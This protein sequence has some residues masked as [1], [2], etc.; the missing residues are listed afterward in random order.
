LEAAGMQAGRRLT[1][2]ELA[3]ELRQGSWLRAVLAG[4]ASADY[5]EAAAGAVA[6]APARV[7][8]LLGH[9]RRT[10]RRRAAEAAAAAL[11]GCGDGTRAA[12]GLAQAVLAS[13]TAAGGEVLREEQAE[14]LGGLVATARRAASPCTSAAAAAPW[15]DWL[16][17]VAAAAAAGLA[18]QTLRAAG[19][20]CRDSNAA[21]H[22]DCARLTAGVA[23]AAAAA[24]PAALAAACSAG[25][26]EAAA[27]LAIAGSPERPSLLVKTGTQG[28]ALQPSSLSQGAAAAAARLEAVG[29]LL[30]VALS[31]PPQAPP[32]GPQVI[33]PVLTA[34]MF[35]CCVCCFWR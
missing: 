13:L 4:N 35:H 34:S 6:E 26:V 7:V 12:V 30:F 8:E 27:A 20:G 11:C 33:N 29:A 28:T 2:A 1:L 14:I 3:A 24:H 31:L 25:F 18:Q 19:D 17:S 10:V 23:L 5:P 22:S 21:A 15:A 32:P 16:A 9:R